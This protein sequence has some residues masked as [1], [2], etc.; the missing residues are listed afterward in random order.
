MTNAASSVILKEFSALAAFLPHVQARHKEIKEMYAARERAAW[1]AT[2]TFVSFEGLKK[3][4]E[5]PMAEFTA[6]VHELEG[7]VVPL[8]LH[9][10]ALGE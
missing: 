3:L 1:Y 4:L 2:R 7:L 8:Q 6:K 5:E 10:P 9:E